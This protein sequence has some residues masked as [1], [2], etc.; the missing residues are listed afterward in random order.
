MERQVRNILSNPGNIV[1][2]V[3]ISICDPG[4]IGNSIFPVSWDPGN[5]TRT[6]NPISNPSPYPFLD[7]CRLNPAN[8]GGPGPKP[9][10]LHGD[11]PGRA[12]GRDP[13][14]QNHW[15]AALYRPALALFGSGCGPAF[16]LSINMFLSIL[17]QKRFLTD[18]L[19]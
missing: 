13:E 4:N 1:K 7:P 6:P 11:T 18:F 12:G 17:F 9:R 3:F 10:P 15:G 16:I 19:I 5:I 14:T 8:A 2:F